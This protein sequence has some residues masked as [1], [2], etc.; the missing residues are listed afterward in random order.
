MIFARCA[1]MVSLTFLILRTTCVATRIEVRPGESLQAVADLVAKGAGADTVYVCLHA[2][3]HRLLAPLQLD[4]R[5][6]HSHWRSCDGAGS[7]TISGGIEIPAVRFHAVG[8]GPLVAAKMDIVGAAGWRTLFVNGVRANRTS[9]NASAALGNLRVTS[10]GYVADRAASWDDTAADGTVE[11]RYFQQLAPWQSQRCLLTR[12]NGQVLT[13]AAACF[14]ALTARAYGVPGLPRNASYGRSGCETPKCGGLLGNPLGSGLPLFVENVPLLGA[15][16]KAISTARPGDFWFSTTSKEL[17][18]YPHDSEMTDAGTFSADVVVPVSEGL[19]SIAGATGLR[20]HGIAFKHSAWSFGELGFIDAQDGIHLA[21]DSKA[22]GEEVVIPGAF[23][24]ENCADVVVEH[25]SFKQLGG[26]AVD[27]GGIAKRCV[28][29]STTIDDVSGS[30]VQVSMLV[31]SDCRHMNCSDVKLQPT[32]NRVTNTTISRAGNEF[33]GCVAIG[34]A[35]NVQLLLSHN[36]LSDL[37]YGGISLGCG[38]SHAGFAH[39]NV[40][41]WNRI[42]RWMMTMQDSAGV[43]M[44]G[45]QPNSSVHHNY[46]AQQGL[47]G[48]EPRPYCDA[49][50]AVPPRRCTAAELLATEDKWMVE[51]NAQKF[52]VT[53]CH[54]SATSA[55]CNQTG[56]AHGGGIY[57]DNGSAGWKAFANVLHEVYHSFF[58]WDSNKMMN[59]SFTQSWTDSLIFTNNAARHHVV[60]DQNHFVNRSAGEPWPTDALHVVNGAGVAAAALEEN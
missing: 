39:S 7:A 15:D 52:N 11:L 41:S 17:Y 38:A 13:V 48:L 33:A 19:V 16:G 42:E 29:D 9:L 60:I 6:S 3:A 10:S 43:Y 35:C 30:G 8:A 49:P 20:F 18:Y 27:F 45:V 34:A 55:F 24:C 40:I 51:M 31:S 28:V 46:I 58:I 44:T 59:M 26:S 5:H 14:A 53:P 37:P 2:G 4:K 23:S 54:R 47:T 57:P 56:N 25:C 1:Q 22:L 12:A 50:L 36:T 32:S 21:A